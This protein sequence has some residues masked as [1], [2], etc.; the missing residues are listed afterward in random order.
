MKFTRK[1]YLAKRCSHREYYGQFVNDGVKGV[2]LRSIGRKAILA[3]TDENFNDIP[4][5]RWDSLAGYYQRVCHSG[6]FELT[7]SALFYCCGRSIC[8]AG[9]GGVSANDL[10]CV[11]KEA[12]RQIREAGDV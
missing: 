1:D 9:S 2:V 11:A 10:V 12:A 4:L 5:H 6:K 7:H 8:E 3:S